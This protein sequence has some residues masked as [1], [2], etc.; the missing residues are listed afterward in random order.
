VQPGAPLV[1]PPVDALAHPP[2]ITAT[3]AA[4]VAA[5]ATVLFGAVKSLPVAS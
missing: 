2:P 4:L 5:P 1:Q 3:A